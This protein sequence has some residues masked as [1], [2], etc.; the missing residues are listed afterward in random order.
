MPFNVSI[1]CLSLLVGVC[2]QYSEA[3]SRGRPMACM[4]ALLQCVQMSSVRGPYHVS[5]GL[6]VSRETGLALQLLVC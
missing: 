4:H 6:A 3:A 1:H 2:Q 5:G